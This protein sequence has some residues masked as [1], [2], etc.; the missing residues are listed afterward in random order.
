[1]NAVSIPGSEE[2]EVLSPSCIE[3]VQHTH[4][5]GEENELGSK[6]YMHTYGKD[7]ACRVFSYSKFRKMHS[8]QGPSVIVIELLEGMQKKEYVEW[9]SI[10]KDI[11][12]A[13]TQT[14]LEIFQAVCKQ[15][16]AIKVD[17]SDGDECVEE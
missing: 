16:Q 10:D 7:V 1:M 15:D 5:Y 14:D 9:M 8:R 17:D 11:P 2:L 6:K 12:T 4:S 3:I 13:A